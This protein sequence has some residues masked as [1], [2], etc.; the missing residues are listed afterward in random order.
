MLRF[1]SKTFLLGE[2]AILQGSNALLLGHGPYF[3]CSHEAG[4]AEAPFH[5]ESPAGVWLKANPVEARLRLQDPHE[6]RGGYGG[7]GA[8]FLCAWSFEKNVPSPEHPRAIFAWS[9]WEDSRALPGSGSGADILVQA[10][11]VNRP[12]PFFLEVDLVGRS[13]KEIYP[14]RS[15]GQLS[16]FHTGRKVAT[17]EQKTPPTLPV[18]ELEDIVIRAGSWL[19]KGLFDGFAREVAAYGEKMAS[20]GLVAPHTLQALAKLPS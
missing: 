3:S 18:E 9:A 19:E 17:H 1:P 15:Q 11:G 8:E 6:G 5:P 16:L 12:E 20:L 4:A 2:Y 13:L 14:M 10:F 7:S